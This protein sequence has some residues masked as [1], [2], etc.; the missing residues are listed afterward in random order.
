MQRLLESKSKSPS[1]YERV[2]NWVLELNKYIE[3]GT[4]IVVA[5]NKTDL[6][7]IVPLETAKEYAKSIGVEHISTSAFD[8]Q[9]TKHL[10]NTLAVKM[11][12]VDERGME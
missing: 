12:E 7:R 4:P 9:V 10:F 8:G 1:S 11:V 2:K 5:G 6:I 3:P